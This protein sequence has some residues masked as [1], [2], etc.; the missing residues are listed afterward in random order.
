[1]NLKRTVLAAG[2]V[3]V[4]SG[5]AVAAWSE[6]WAPLTRMALVNSIER[7]GLSPGKVTQIGDHY[8]QIKKIIVVDNGDGSFSVTFTPAKPN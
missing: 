3:A 6:K 8:Y 7:V 1:M 5:A 2:I 4:T